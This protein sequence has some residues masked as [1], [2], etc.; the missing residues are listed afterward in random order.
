MTHPLVYCSHTGS[1]LKYAALELQAHGIPVVDHPTPEVTH[2]LLDIPT[3]KVPEG[4]LERL[5]ERITVVGGNLD[6]PE[7]QGYQTLDLLQ[8]DE[9]LAIN[10]GITADCALRVAVQ[11]MET[12]FRDTPTLVIGWGRIGKCLCQLLHSLHVPVTVAARKE[13]D[14]AILQ[15]LGFRTADPAHL[16]DLSQYRLIFNTAPS[17]VLN[18]K[19]LANCANCIKIDLASVPGMDGE[20]VIWARGLPGI[21]APKSSGRLI[22]EIFMKRCKE[23]YT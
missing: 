12:T 5:P 19:K 10:A 3:R 18:R 4:L 6:F 1:A 11:R 7:L 17:P 21:Y 23:D 14:R 8:N 2:L 13:N 20:D 9:Y 16:A 22:A 15:A